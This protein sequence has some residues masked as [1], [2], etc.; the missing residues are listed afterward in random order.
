MCELLAERIKGGP[1]N[2]FLGNVWTERGNMLESEASALFEMITGKTPKSAGFIYKNEDRRCGCS[3]DWLMD[4]AGAEF[5]CPGEGRHVELMLADGNIPSSSYFP[6]V[7]F[8]MWVTGL[9]KWYLMSY[10]PDFPPVIMEVLSEECWQTAFD[11]CVPM[12]L[13]D[14]DYAWRELLGKGVRYEAEEN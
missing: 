5:K 8:S 1:V 10:A 11:E 13:S 4:D 7:Q 9:D 3:P 2:A 14:M 12:F 6:Q